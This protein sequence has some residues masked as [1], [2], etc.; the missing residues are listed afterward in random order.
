MISAVI[1]AL[2]LV[3]SLYFYKKGYS[4]SDLKKLGSKSDQHLIETSTGSQ[5]ETDPQENLIVQ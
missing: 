4:L 2:L 1:L 3:V 5:T